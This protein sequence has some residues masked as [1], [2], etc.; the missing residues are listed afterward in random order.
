MIHKLYKVIQKYTNVNIVFDVF[1]MNYVYSKRN[2]QA[3]KIILQFN[4]PK[5]MNDFENMLRKND[6]LGSAM[7]LEKYNLLYGTKLGLEKYKNKN[8][9]ITKNIDNFIK[10][11]GPIIGPQKWDEYR[12]KQAI[13]NTFNYKKDKHN[14]T[15]QD[16]D[17]YNKKRA[18]TLANFIKKYGNDIGIDKWNTYKN[19]QAF[20]NTK[21]HLG[22]KYEI[23]NSQKGLTLQNAIRKYGEIDGPIYFNEWMQKLNSACYS[24]ISQ[25]LFD[26][27]SIH[28]LFKNEKLYYAT[29]NYEYGLYDEKLKRYFKYDFV[30]SSLK[31]CIEYNGDHYHGNTIIYSA[32]DF[33]KG[34]GCTK[35][36]A[37]DKWAEDA[38]KIELLKTIKNY[39]TLIV[40]DSEYRNNENMVIERIINYAQA[41]I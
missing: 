35:I 9:K 22:E 33:L 41:R 29:K 28:Q 21:E 14:F 34:R 36:K 25:I 20:T 37:K 16:F 23:I 15:K 38:Y 17:A 8:S 1:D 13:S 2:A 7:N 11:Y 19:R 31:I 39:D 27:I 30:C 18:C 10:K 6:F 4:T 26:S 3:F 5:T 32:D 12:K 40:W 24:K